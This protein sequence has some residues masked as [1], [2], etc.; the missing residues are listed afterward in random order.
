M[1]TKLHWQLLL[2]FPENLSR[3]KCLEYVNLAMNN[4]ETIE[5]LDGCENL[6]KLDLTLNF[7]GAIS[8]VTKLRNNHFLDQL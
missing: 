5:G 8:S 7:V 3:L 4:I 1:E 2:P 6:K